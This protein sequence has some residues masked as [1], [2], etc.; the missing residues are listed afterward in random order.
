VYD[1]ADRAAHRGLL[2]ALA[3]IAFLEGRY[4]EASKHVEAIRA[5]EEKPADKLI[6]GMATRTMVAA[7][8]KAGS[9]S[10]EAYHQEV[11][12]LMAV[13]LAQL[14]YPVIANDIKRYKSQAEVIGEALL[15]GRVRDQL[16]PVVDKAAASWVRTSRPSS[17]APA[18]ASW[19]ACH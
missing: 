19:H 18:P 2:D 5:L 17:C 9:T 13:E 7:Q 4:D 3:Q 15:L 8:A 6:S 11:G 14:P 12:R 10:S 1:I 16:Q